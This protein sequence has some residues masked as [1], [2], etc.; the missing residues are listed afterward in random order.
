MLSEDPRAAELSALATRRRQDAERFCE[1]ILETDDI[2]AAPPEELGLL[3]IALASAKAAFAEDGG[4][5]L[6]ESCRLQEE[7]LLRQVE[8]AT[9][10]PLRSSETAAARD[11]AASA[12]S[13]LD[14]LLRT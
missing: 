11:L 8:A 13:W 9:E 1:Q 10:A 2:P 3:E 12:R 4:T 7:N 14:G 5:A 6:L